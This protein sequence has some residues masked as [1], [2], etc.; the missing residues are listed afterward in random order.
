MF[1]IDFKG[2][3]KESRIRK[4]IQAL[5]ASC[6]FMKTLGSYPSGK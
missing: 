2:H 6:I 4:A 3:Q 5:Q 1:F